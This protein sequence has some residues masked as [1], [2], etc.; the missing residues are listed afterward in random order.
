MPLQPHPEAGKAYRRARRSLFFLLVITVLLSV[1]VEGLATYLWTVC[2]NYLR[3]WFVLLVQLLL[4]VGLVYVGSRYDDQFIGEARTNIDLLLPYVVQWK[5]RRTE[6]GMRPSY[7]V[8]REAQ[9]AWNSLFPAGLPV[10]GREGAFYVHIKPEH[11]ALVRHLLVMYLAR[12]T[13]GERE[14]KPTYKWL[15]L[16]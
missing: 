2:Q 13:K 9:K 12:F 1:A 7:R 5:R 3:W 11:F 4:V 6:L 15:R 16:M 8:T 14:E 10:Q